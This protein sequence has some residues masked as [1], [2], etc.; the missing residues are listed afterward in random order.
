[1]SHGRAQDILQLDSEVTCLEFHPKL[2]HTF[3]TSQSNGEVCL[4]D[5]R[6]DFGSATSRSGG[7]E[8]LRACVSTF[9]SSSLALI[10][11][12]SIKQEQQSLERP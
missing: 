5:G 6:M 4:R 3:V 7:G 8:V 2:E 9:G 11:F 10:E 12:Y 1:M